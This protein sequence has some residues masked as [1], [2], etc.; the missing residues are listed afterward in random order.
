ML[1]YHIASKIRPQIKQH[2]EFL[3]N[4]VIEGKLDSELRVNAALEFL[5]SN[6]TIKDI[7]TAQLDQTCG[8][9]VVVTPEQIEGRDFY[10]DGQML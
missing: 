6:A 9:G 10:R 7:D 1:L 5:I 3:V 2:V 4:Y 8:V